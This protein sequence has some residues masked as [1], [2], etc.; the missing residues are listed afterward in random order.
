MS[1]AIQIHKWIVFLLR[2]VSQSTQAFKF[3][4]ALH[5]GKNQ[6]VGDYRDVLNLGQFVATKPIF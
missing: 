6:K 1:T 5:Q 2:T 4:K 3:S